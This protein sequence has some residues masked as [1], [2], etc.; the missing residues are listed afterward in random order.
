[1]GGFHV[2][3][4]VHDFANPR[5]FLKEVG[6]GVV[7]PYRGTVCRIRTKG[8]D[9]GCFIVVVVAAAVVVGVGGGCCF[10]CCS[11]SSSFGML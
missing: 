3:L 9:I 8:A 5:F 11:S 10:C 7:C 6:P 2:K 4:Q 1:M